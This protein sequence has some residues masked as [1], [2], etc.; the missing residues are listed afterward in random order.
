VYTLWVLLPSKSEE[1]YE[2]Y[3]RAGA[4]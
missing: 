4:A 1:D 2:N 3:R